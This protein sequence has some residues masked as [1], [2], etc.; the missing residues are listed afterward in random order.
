LAE[1]ATPILRLSSV[2]SD[3]G[4]GAI[5]LPEDF[6]LRG[7]SIIITNRGKPVTELVAPRERQ[8]SDLNAL[9]SS[10]KANR[11]GSIN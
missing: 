10:I 1:I 11:V 9:I 8:T 5:A 4:C 3:G 6:V 2:L 7:E